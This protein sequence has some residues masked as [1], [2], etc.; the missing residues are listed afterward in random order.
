[1][2]SFEVPIVGYIIFTQKYW[3]IDN[4]LF[5]GDSILS[6]IWFSLFHHL[7]D[8][9]SK[10]K[11]IALKTMILS[12]KN[13]RRHISWSSAGIRGVDL[14]PDASIAKVNQSDVAIRVEY[15]ICWTDISV[16]NSIGVKKF[17]SLQDTCDNELSLPLRKLFAL[18]MQ[19]IREVSSRIILRDQVEHRFILEG[20]LH[21]R[22]EWT[23]QLGHQSHFIQNSINASCLENFRL[24]NSF[25]DH[26]LLR[27]QL[28]HNPYLTKLT[29]CYIFLEDEMCLIDFISINSQCEN[30]II[31]STRC[32]EPITVW[33]HHTC[34]GEIPTSLYTV[35]IYFLIVVS[36]ISL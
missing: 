10:C 31:F 29:L 25:D 28:S 27:W 17:E 34:F 18:V 2:G 4:L 5:V 24:M 13:F 32:H 20:I 14:L 23:H 26:F 35:L 12:E 21:I 15:Q 22:D 11:E 3:F 1:M 33:I 30:P 8:Y 19:I 9:H 36:H 16:H 6:Q 7:E